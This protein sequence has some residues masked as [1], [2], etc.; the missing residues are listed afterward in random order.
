MK[1]ANIIE[2]SLTVILVLAFIYFL[3]NIRLLNG[4]LEPY[5][6]ISILIAGILILVS[7]R[8]INSEKGVDA[9][10]YKATLDNLSEDNMTRF[11]RRMCGRGQEFA[12]F[13]KVKPSRSLVSFKNELMFL[14]QKSVAH[15]VGKIVWNEAFI[16]L[17]DA[18][19]APLNQERGWQGYALNLVKLD[20]A[21]YSAQ[22]FKDK[23]S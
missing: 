5:F 16:G 8:W 2:T 6:K 23:L 3:A 19:I 7:P 17:K 9:A 1:T 21:H 22:F 13:I 4:F 12:A 14:A 11:Y 10:L 18:I 20:A 15:R